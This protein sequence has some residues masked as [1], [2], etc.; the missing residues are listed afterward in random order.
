MKRLLQQQTNGHDVKLFYKCLCCGTLY[1]PTFQTGSKRCKNCGSIDFLLLKFKVPKHFTFKRKG[2][3]SINDA[4]RIETVKE[5]NRGVFELNFE[6]LAKGAPLIISTQPGVY[7]IKL[8]Y[9]LE[10]LKTVNHT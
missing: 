10:K 5:S 2:C 8:E 3:Y 1:S 4:E 9:E 6:A 7:E